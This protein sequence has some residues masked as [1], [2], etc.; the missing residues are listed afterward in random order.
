M[1]EDKAP[2]G[3]SPSS[4]VQ[5]PVAVQVVDHV[6]EIVA[7]VCLTVLACRHVLSGE[8]ALAGILATLGVQSGLRTFGRRGV[9]A[10]GAAVLLLLPALPIAGRALRLA[11]IALLGAALLFSPLGCGPTPVQS[12]ALL[13]VPGVPP[14]VGCAPAGAT[15]CQGATPEVCSASGRWWAALPGPCPGGCA[16]E[17]AGARCLAVDAGVSP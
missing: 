13:L 16:L 14:A 10:V 1:A 15:R 9:G 12:A 5:P 8:L 7:I 17:D 11:G 3:A 6:G 2:Q 4:S